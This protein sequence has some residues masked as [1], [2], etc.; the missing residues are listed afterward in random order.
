MG[1]D[2]YLYQKTNTGP[3]E[4]MYWRKA[5]AIHKWFVDNVQ[6]GVD[7]CQPH[8]VTITQL[9]E[10][11]ELCDRVLLE[12]SISKSAPERLLPTQSGFFFGS[13]DYDEH[14]FNDV[15]ETASTLETI[16]VN[17]DEDTVFVYQSSW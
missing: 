6:N 9:K 13:T 12:S 15:Q 5:N 7:K 10:L 11:K 17:I 1:L 14:Y 3:I 8:N 4:V 2:M 16:L